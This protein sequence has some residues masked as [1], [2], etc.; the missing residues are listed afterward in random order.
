MTEANLL[1]LNDAI[2]QSH[3]AWGMLSMGAVTPL[4]P[5][6]RWWSVFQEPNGLFKSGSVRVFGD[7]VQG[8][9]CSMGFQGRISR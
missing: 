6:Q 7:E 8:Q 3:D 1:E 5:S 4:R 9:Y 2:V